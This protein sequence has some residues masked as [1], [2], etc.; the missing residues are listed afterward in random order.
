[1]QMN[2]EF[3]MIAAL[4][5]PCVLACFTYWMRASPSVEEYLQQKK[6]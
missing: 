4:S 5:R 3:E 6:A 2:G 1:M